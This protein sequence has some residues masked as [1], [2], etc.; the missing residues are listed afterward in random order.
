MDAPGLEFRVLGP[1]EAV[2]GG[3]EVPLASGRQRAL[4]ACLLLAAGR[5][6]PVASLVDRL[7]DDDPPRD[8]RGTLQVHLFRL[9]RALGDAEIVRTRPGGYLME[10]GPDDLRRLDALADGADRAREAGDLE[11]ALKALRAAT[12]LWR[13]PILANVTSSSLHAEET[14]KLTERCLKTVE[15]RYELELVLGHH[16]AAVADLRA[17]AA[18]HPLRESLH[19]LLMRALYRSGRQAEAL[20]A[21]DRTAAALGEEFGLDPGDALKELRQAILTR[22]EDR[23]VHPAVPWRA[24]C[25]LPS[26][27]GDFTGRV[28]EL[29]E[30]ERLLAPGGFAAPVVTVCGTAGVGK[31]ALAVRAAHRSRERFPDGQLYASLGDR[32]PAEVAG[33]FLRAL[34]VP[35]EAVPDG[36]QARAAALRARLTDRRVLLVLDDAS[37][38][39]QV[40]ALLPGT[41]G[42]AVL[43][44]S[45]SPLAELPGNRAVRLAPFTPEEAAGLLRRMVGDGR[46]AAEPE[47]ARRVAEACGHLPLALRIAGARL[48]AH[49]SVALA[50]L[51]R[52]LR[53][54]GRRLDELS[55][56]GLEV[57]AGLRVGYRALDAAA[58]GAFRRLG[59]VARADVTA[60]LLSLLSGGDRERPL[61]DLVNAG[62]LQPSGV[63]ASGEPR[64]RFHDLTADF[65]AELAGPP[66]RPANRAALV[67]LTAALTALAALA[68]HARARSSNDLP[69]EDV[70]GAG[71]SAIDADLL[72]AAFRGGAG[73]PI[74][75]LAAHRS[76]IE[77]A[78]GRACAAG[79]YEP[80]ARLVDL[81]V[82]LLHRQV[83][84]AALRRL[85]R[86]VRDAARDAE[87]E[88][89]MWREE[90]GLAVLTLYAAPPAEAAEA[91]RACASAFERLGMHREQSYALSML[92]FLQVQA[93]DEVTAWE[94]SFTLAGRAVGLAR[95]AGDQRAQVVALSAKADALVSSE[96]Y[97]EALAAAQ[98]AL[99][100]ART[101]GEPHFQATALSRITR[102]TL[103][104]GDA[105]GAAEACQEA[106]R[107]LDGLQDRRSAAWLLRES[108]LIALARGRHD[109]AA[110]LAERAASHFLDLGDRHGHD[111]A[112][113]TLSGIRRPAPVAEQAREP[114]L[115]PAWGG[116]TAG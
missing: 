1:L 42:C 85:R 45:R 35:P 99:G 24:L 94:E 56:G 71:P 44:T 96:R 46:V 51:D 104:L 93:P 72:P 92:T 2:R 49:P 7:W 15:R 86:I 78:V 65:A 5:P 28:R 55:V 43:V 62:L 60:W 61:E 64:Y 59:L 58:A 116:R 113:A 36:P 111:S 18:A 82:P 20:D 3:R 23:G 12:A 69:A 106:M 14:P 100:L 27:P 4:L 25:Q 105:D 103:E 52:R 54:D 83:D 81:V 29:A 50:A 30:V 101:L 53:E 41:A 80:A 8:A 114:G 73:E 9:R 31:T 32:D 76:L 21:Y 70:A 19:G 68:Q 22:T 17:L 75:W 48:A 40:E 84:A 110:A 39:G 91:A 87:D 95:E 33:D 90:Y 115:G 10:Q 112:A 74:D 37:G 97:D 26:P 67:R 79:L 57:R 107:L 108:A 89:I 11:G 77:Q 102:C 66:D 13:G 109:E 63:D 88:P 98:E 34:G 38:A 16:E 47:A 6:V